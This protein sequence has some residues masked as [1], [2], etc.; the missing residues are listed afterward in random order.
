MGRHLL[1]LLTT[2]SLLVCVAA[3]ALWVRSYWAMYWVSYA[4]VTPGEQVGPAWWVTIQSGRGSVGAGVMVL[5][6]RPGS[7]IPRILGLRCGTAT[8]RTPSRVSVGATRLGFGYESHA[9]A[10]DVVGRWRE[11]DVVVPSWSLPLFFA[12]APALWVYRRR[13]R[14]CPTGLCRRC[15][16]DLRATP[17]RCPECGAVAP[18]RPAP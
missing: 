6:R 8:A 9:D 3:C 11:W 4:R 2:F 13:C 12:A 16:Y 7:P 14:P 10:D 1:N 5:E 18:V 15:G 17:E